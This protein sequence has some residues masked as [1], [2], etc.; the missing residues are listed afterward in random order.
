MTREVP[1]SS[2]VTQEKFPSKGEIADELLQRLGQAYKPLNRYQNYA[3]QPG[4]GYYRCGKCGG[5]HRTDQC[6]AIPEPFKQTPVKKWC[7]LCQWN[8]THETK[9]CN[10]IGRTPP[11]PEGRVLQTYQPRGEAARP[12]L[13]NQPTPPGMT[14]LRYISAEVPPSGMEMVSA[15]P[16]YTEPEYTIAE[17]VEQPQELQLIEMPAQG[18][19]ETGSLMLIQAPMRPRAPAMRKAGPC[20]GC[21]GD[22]WLRDCPDKMII[23]YKGERLPPIERYCV[24]CSVDHLPKMCPH[25]PTPAAPTNPNPNPNVRP[26]QALNYIEV[27]P[28]PFAEEEEKDRASLRV[29]TRARG[30]GR[31]AKAK[32]RD[33]GTKEEQSRKRSPKR[34]GRPRKEKKSRVGSESEGEP[35]KPLEPQ[36]KHQDKE[37]TNDHVSESSSSSHKGGSVLIDKINEPIEA[38]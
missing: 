8:Y 35:Q 24:G 26:N 21:G 22:H 15:Q 14:S 25:R 32:S 30:M 29:I 31:S 38:A 23:G 10:R 13:G 6:D 3:P 1:V 17:P 7:Q 27:I 37:E 16:Y 11:V 33:S 28:S 20:F 9:D 19:E 4:G 2:V 34:R 12:V 5:P 18:D 36:P